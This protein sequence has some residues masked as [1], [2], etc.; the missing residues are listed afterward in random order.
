MEYQQLPTDNG[1][2]KFLNWKPNTEGHAGTH[3]FTEYRIKG[4]NECIKTSEEKNRDFQEIA[5]LAPNEVYEF[6]FVAVDGHFMTESSTQEVDINDIDGPIKVPNQNV[7]NDGW[8]I[9][10]ML[11]LAIIIKLFIIICIIRRNRGGKYDV[12]D[13]E[14]ANGRRDYPEDG[15]FHEYSQPLDNKSA[16]RQS[17]SSAKPGLESDTDSMAEYGDGD[18]G[19]NED[20]SFNGQYGRKGL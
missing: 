8:F 17:V 5:G 13:R 20:G 3:F 16:G 12:H 1:L 10:M 9:G 18:T 7:A 14:L 4:E 2:A 11:A 6:R 19:M 15:G